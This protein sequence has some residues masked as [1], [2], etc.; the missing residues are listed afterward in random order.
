M[1][2]K[3]KHPINFIALVLALGSFCIGTLILILFK[4]THLDNLLI[5]GYLYTWL[6][7]ILNSIMLLLLLLNLITK[8]KDYSENLLTILGLLLNIPITLFYMDIV[9]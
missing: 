7:A 4:I 6:A 2:S 1:K 5:L 9:L 8:Y 3:F